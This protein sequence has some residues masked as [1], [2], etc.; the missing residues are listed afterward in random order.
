MVTSLNRLIKIQGIQMKQ[1][2][3]IDVATNELLNQCVAA[4]RLPET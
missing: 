3:H 1:V 2:F 4:H